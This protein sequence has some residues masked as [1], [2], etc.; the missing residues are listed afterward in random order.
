MG[1]EVLYVTQ[2]SLAGKVSAAIAT[3]GLKDRGAK[4]RSDLYFLNN[5]DKPAILLEICFVDSQA[6]CDLYQCS[7]SQIVEAIADALQGEAEPTVMIETTG[8]VR[9]FLNGRRLE[10]LIPLL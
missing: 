5:T 7:F 4:H 1:C 8:R 10:K 2:E 9:V 3:S 6:D